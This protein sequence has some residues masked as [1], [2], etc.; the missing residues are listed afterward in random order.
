MNVRLVI[1]VDLVPLLFCVIQL[2]LSFPYF[3]F[4]KSNHGDCLF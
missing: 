4:S 2:L 3:A 1:R